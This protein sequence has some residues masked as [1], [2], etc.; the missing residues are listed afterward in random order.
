[1]YWIM[2]HNSGP[3]GEV[4]NE[5]GSLMTFDSRE[6]AEEWAKTNLAFEWVVIY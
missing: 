4:L 1:M 3:I 2:E 5:D 6:E